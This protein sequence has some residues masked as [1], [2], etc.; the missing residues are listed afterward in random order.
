MRIDSSDELEGIP[1]P[2]IRAAFREVGLDG[3]IST[4][5]FRRR[6]RLS[7][8]RADRLIASLRRLKLL[9]PI[10]A[11]RSGQAAPGDWLLT[12]QGIRLR[13][14]TA[15]KPI[16]RTTADR[17]LSDLLERIE[18]LNG[19]GRFLGRVRKAVVFGSYIGDAD[20]IG[21]IDV[22][23]EIVRREPDFE[24]HTQ[25]NNRRVAEEFAA[26]RRFSN[27]LEQAFW[28]QTEAFLFLRNRKRGLSLQDYGA[29][30][31]IVAA[32][33]HR[34][35]FEDSGRRRS[36]GPSAAQRPEKT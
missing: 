14:A 30:K 33:P 31:E 15:A 18:K 4:D 25:A 17:L 32:A 34:V 1:L 35:V 36:R 12:D 13:A 27:I 26:G 19:D 20:Q 8:A 11:R 23:V 10:P 3:I 24:K 21:D 5:F 2:E 7:K 9:K 28:W 22:A 29:I 16:R 6:F